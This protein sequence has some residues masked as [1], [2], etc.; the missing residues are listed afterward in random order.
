MK[1]KNLTPKNLIGTKWEDFFQAIDNY[2]TDFK[3]YKIAILKNK[4]VTTT[5]DKVNLRD[6][7]KQKG[8][9]I[10]ELNGYSSTLE[11]I[12]RRATNI[13][14][15]IL[16]LLSETCY[17]YILKSF[18]YYGFV[19]GLVE[20]PDGYYY[21]DEPATT[22]SSISK[23]PQLLDQE[24]DVIYY[25][26]GDNPVPNP[27]IKTYQPAI[28]LDDEIAPNLDMDDIRDGTN[29]F[30]IEYGFYKCESKDV[31][32]SEN[33]SRALYDTIKQVHRLKEVPHYRAILPFTL[34][35]NGSINTKEFQSYDGLQENISSVKTIYIQGNF[36]VVNFIEVGSSYHNIIDNTITSCKV[37]IGVIPVNEIFLVND[38]SASG[39]NIEYKIQEYNKFKIPSGV[40]IYK[41]SEITFLDEDLNAVAYSTFPE[42]NF[43][44]EKYS[45]IKIE[46]TCQD[47]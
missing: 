39:L 3:N 31:F 21:R 32:C 11:Y 6:L 38:R 23:E 14:L 47:I 16:Y 36:N 20:D 44:S 28:F 41:F 18:W 5:D 34:N 7:V 19:Y 17:K 2:F 22:I 26:N 29:H 12:Q 4:F 27:P 9:N 15:E 8:Y 13:P 45:G 35:T 42:I 1:L 30:L 46:I 24:V 40:N 10:I 43:Y 25:Y 37:P 33:T